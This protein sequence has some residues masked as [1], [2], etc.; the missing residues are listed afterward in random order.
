MRPRGHGAGAQTQQQAADVPH[1]KIKF[2]RHLRAGSF[3]VNSPL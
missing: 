3:A 2:G 1:G